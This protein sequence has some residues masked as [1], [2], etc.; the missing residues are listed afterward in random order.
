[1]VPAGFNRNLNKLKFSFTNPPIPAMLQAY[2]FKKSKPSYL[3]VINIKSGIMKPVTDQHPEKPQKP[4]E[5][6][7]PPVEPPT[8][9][10][11][12]PSP[13]PWPQKEP[14]I[15]PEEPPSRE[16]PTPQEVPPPPSKN[17]STP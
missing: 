9:P 7:I 4:N 17:Q 3:E 10:A 11:E 15:V 6:P 14:E 13:R 16:E 12:E 1:M 5:L 8:K 2:N